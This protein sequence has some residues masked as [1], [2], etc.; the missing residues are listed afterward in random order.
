MCQ[1]Q[2]GS[3]EMAVSV[4]IWK[5]AISDERNGAILYPEFCNLAWFGA[6]WSLCLSPRKRYREIS[7][8]FRRNFDGL[9]NISGNGPYIHQLPP[10]SK[11]HLVSTNVNCIFEIMYYIWCS[12]S[13]LFCKFWDN[14]KNILV[15]F[16]F[17]SWIHRY[18][19]N[20]FSS[21]FLHSRS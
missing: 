16:F 8:N 1:L 20:R 3:N 9:P 15:R 11:K 13:N 21:Y 4:G 18:F 12:N 17:V 14:L 10:I 19:L 2:K 7:I 6:D 5:C